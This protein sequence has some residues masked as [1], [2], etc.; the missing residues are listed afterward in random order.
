MTGYRVRYDGD[1]SAMTAARHAVI[2]FA[3]SCGFGP[4][5]LAD[6]ASAV[7]E[8]LSNAAMHGR[9]EHITVSCAFDD[10]SLAV[11][12][13]DLGAGFDTKAE[14]KRRLAG[15]G[16]GFGIPIMRRLM[17]SVTHSDGGRKVTLTKRLLPTAAP[18]LQASISHHR[19]EQSDPLRRESAGRARR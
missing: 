7:G 12:I 14:A 1:A 8:G 4:A 2:D 10:H 16:G 9:G 19:D 18:P 17:D 11:E 5:D 6:I 15:M 13:E 3:R